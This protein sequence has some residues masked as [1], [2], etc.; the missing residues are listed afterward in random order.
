M[1]VGVGRELGLLA[2]HGQEARGGEFRQEHRTLSSNVGLWVGNSA[3]CARSAE[4]SS[5]L[6]ERISEGDAFS[7]LE[8]LRP[9]TDGKGWKQ[10]A[11]SG[12][13]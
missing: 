4:K 11:D 3:L 10:G 7:Y 12:S 8:E 1:D 2:D 5:A 9:K 6:C 13:D